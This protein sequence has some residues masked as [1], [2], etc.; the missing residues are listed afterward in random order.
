[1]TDNNIE[2]GKL[3]KM[4]WR[5]RRK[6]AIAAF[7]WTVIQTLLL[8]FAIPTEKIEALNIPIT[9]SYYIMGG[10]VVAYMGFKAFGKDEMKSE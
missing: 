10:I 2:N 1:M 5:S 4:T 6:M 8:F 9:S 3:T 7:S